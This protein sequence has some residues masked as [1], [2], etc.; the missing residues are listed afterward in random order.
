MSRRALLLAALACLVGGWHSWKY[1]AQHQPPGILVAEEPQQRGIAAPLPSIARGDFQLLRRAHYALTARLLA[2]ETYRLGQGA[3]LAPLDFALGWGPMSDSG[4]LDALEVH[5]S[6]RFFHVRWSEP[7]IAASEIMAH[8]A[9]VHLIAA[10]GGV[11]RA[12]DRM[13]PG[14]VVQLQGYLVDALRSDGWNWTTSLTRRDTGAGA[15]EL[16]LVESA[17]LR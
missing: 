1:R 10:D 5:Q 3:D 13:R 17:S 8:A 2:R 11:A 4:V 16:M 7:P 6:G 15:C 9:N 14:Q 12:L